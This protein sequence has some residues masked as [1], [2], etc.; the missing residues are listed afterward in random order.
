MALTDV[1]FSSDNSASANRGDVGTVTDSSSEKISNSLF[2]TV[3]TA[4][5]VESGVTFGHQGTELTGSF[6]GGGGGGSGVSRGRIAN[7]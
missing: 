4:A 2:I 1:V 3:P 7:A 6:I 5:Q